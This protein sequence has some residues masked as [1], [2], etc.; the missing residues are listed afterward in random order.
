M[1]TR[2]RTHRRSAAWVP[3]Q[4][5]AWFM[6]TVPPLTGLALRPTWTAL[7]VTATWLAG[8][9][10]FFAVSVWLRSRRQ[11]RHRPPVIAYSALTT[12]CGLCAL[13][14][15]VSLLKWVPLIA[16]LAAIAIWETY[17]RRPRSLV[18]GVSTV[19]AASLMVPV[20]AGASARAWA[21]GLIYAGFF[22]G[23]VPY[24]KTLIRERGSTA[25][26][27]GSVAYHLALACIAVA[28]FVRVGAPLIKVG[29]PAVAALL[30]I[31]SF[32]MPISGAARGRPWTPKQ[33]GLLDAV[34]TVA[35]VVAAW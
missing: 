33:V 29:V 12:A 11:L 18:S 34:L 26:L 16:P 22:V 4:H 15:D 30:L 14:A 28:A 10:A 9:F 3:D 20:V 25:W 8:Y 13:L 35:V 19:L 6:V 27:A 24:V 21:I 17:R 7:L 32:T 31:R 1:S 5:G 23:T 2:P